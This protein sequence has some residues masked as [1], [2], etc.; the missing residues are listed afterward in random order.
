MIEGLDEKPARARGRIEHRL[1]EARIVGGGP[2][3]LS[4][5]G[6]Q[7]FLKFSYD[8]AQV[9]GTTEQSDYIR[10]SAVFGNRRDHA[11]VRKGKSRVA[12]LGVFLDEFLK[13]LARALAVAFEK[14][15]AFGAEALRPFA[16]RAQRRVERD[17]A[18]QIERVGFP[19][20]GRF[21]QLDEVDAALSQRRNNFRPS[22]TVQRAKG[23]APA[24]IHRRAATDGAA[25]LEVAKETGSRAP[26]KCC[27][28]KSL[29]GGEAE[30]GDICQKR[31]AGQRQ[32]SAGRQQPG[33]PG[34]GTAQQFRE[35]TQTAL[36][37]G[38]GNRQRG[39]RATGFGF[40]DPAGIIGEL[41]R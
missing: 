30:T 9:I 15:L 19:L 22:H 29:P 2:S 20:P 10:P 25:V 27:D 18:Q 14:V 34:A 37:I 28:R 38:A 40:D 31:A 41:S 4:L 1:A 13:H 12:V 32:W 33:L 17:V 26:L 21:A 6:I 7:M 36:D 5:R 11:H 23:K 35:Y 3:F 8:R 16:S 39:R 24:D